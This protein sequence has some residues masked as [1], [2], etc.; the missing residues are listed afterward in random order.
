MPSGTIYGNALFDGTV[1]ETT[2]IN[3]TN[4]YGVT[5]HN[6][7]VGTDLTAL[8]QLSSSL[9]GLQGPPLTMHLG[10]GQS[11]TID[12]GSNSVFT[13]AKDGFRFADNSTL[14]ING[15]WNHYVVLNF[16]FNVV[17]SGN[18]F[19]TIVIRVS[20]SKWRQYR[21]PGREAGV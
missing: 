11:M 5:G 18:R 20:A 10:S 8:N 4:I 15:P 21:S 13:V 19:G 17:F 1:K 12:A 16:N 14:I 6:G 9:A 7:D 3:G 2:A